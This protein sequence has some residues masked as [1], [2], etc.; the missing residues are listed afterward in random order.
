MSRGARRGGAGGTLGRIAESLGI[1][2][3]EIASLTAVKKEPPPLYPVILYGITGVIA[4]I[5]AFVSR[6]TSFLYAKRVRLYGRN[7]SRAITTFPRF[8]FL[9]R[10]GAKKRC[11]SLH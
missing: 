1:S 4:K 10:E 3:N 2:R 8:T 5:L 9:L 11:S 7:K 6:P